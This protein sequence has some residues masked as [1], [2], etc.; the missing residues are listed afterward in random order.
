[1]IKR[2][3]PYLF[4]LISGTAWAAGAAVPLMESGANI[5]DK[6]SLQRGAALFV[7][8]C[9]GCHSLQ[10]MRYN[11]IAR[12]LG[13]SEQQVMEY[14]NF[15]GAKFGDTI[16]AAMPAGLGPDSIGAEDWFGKAPP[17]LSLTARV[18]GTDWIF[19]YL[20]SFYPDPNR[21]SG[22]NNT[23]FKDAS[24]PNVLWDRQGIQVPRPTTGEDHGGHV[25]A[26]QFDLVQPG[27]RSPE[28]F[29]QD[30]RDIAAFLEYVG[31][32][33]ALERRA[34]GIWVLLYLLLFTGLAWLLKQEYWKDVH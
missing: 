15:T 3:L 6:A 29:R 17:D 26:V 10:Y 7:N 9:G 14:L 28:E 24:M 1:M 11:R 27:S 32:P 31:E 34:Y 12:D 25:A 16:H 4:A 18:R 30:A 33:A 20:M 2:L 22:W 21:P 23:V 13:L 8:Y 19:S 5:L